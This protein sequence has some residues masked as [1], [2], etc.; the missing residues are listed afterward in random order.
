MKFR[1]DGE[2]IRVSI[3]P[4]ENRRFISLYPGEVYDLP[5][6]VAKRPGLKLTPI[7]A[8]EGKI[9]DKKVETKVEAKNDATA[10]QDKDLKAFSRELSSIKGIGKKT[11]QDI[12][13]VY[14]SKEALLK[15]IKEKNE[16]PFRDDVDK[17]LRDHYGKKRK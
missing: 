8:L 15:E 6:E 11:V 17:K 13:A 4:S 14:P 10:S 2:W 1:N 3:G 16:L 5:E 12:I 9:G 7:Q